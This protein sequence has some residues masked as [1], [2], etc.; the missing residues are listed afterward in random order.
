MKKQSVTPLRIKKTSI[1][2]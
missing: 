1:K 2:N